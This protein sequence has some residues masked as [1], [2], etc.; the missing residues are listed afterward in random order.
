MAKVAKNMVVNRMQ[1]GFDV[2]AVVLKGQL[3]DEAEE[4]G[5]REERK[6]FRTRCTDRR[7]EEVTEKDL[8]DII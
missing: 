1:K 7:R 3:P 5:R 8:L 2:V 6:C 4:S